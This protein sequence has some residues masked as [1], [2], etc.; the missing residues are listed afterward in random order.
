MEHNT[1]AGNEARARCQVFGECQVFEICALLAPK[2]NA[3]PS[4]V[5]AP[6]IKVGMTVTV[7]GATATVAARDSRYPNAWFIED[8]Q[9]R[10]ASVARYMIDVAAAS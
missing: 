3:K 5:R 6:S 10:R 1:E 7:L 9:G 4:K 8:G 2:K